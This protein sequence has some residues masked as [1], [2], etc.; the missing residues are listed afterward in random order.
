MEVGKKSK[1][2]VFMFAIFNYSKMPKTGISDDSEDE[3]EKASLLGDKQGVVQKGKGV[4]AAFLR[5][6]ALVVSSASVQLLE[7]RIPDFELNTVRCAVPFL[8]SAIGMVT[9][10]QLPVI[11]REEIGSTTLYSL[12]S[13]TTSITMY[14]AVTLLPVSTMQ[15][16]RETCNIISGII[17]FYIFLNE[18]PTCS[19][20]ISA[21][22]CICGVILVI[23]PSFIFFNKDLRMMNETLILFDDTNNNGNGTMVSFVSSSGIMVNDSMMTKRSTLKDDSS[24]ILEILKYSLPLLSGLA[25]C[26]DVVLVKKRPYLTE[27][28]TEVLF[29]C[30]M[31]NTIIS[32]VTMFIWE[33][34]VLPSSWFDTLLVTL[35]C[36]AY[37]FI[38]PLY[39]YSLRHIA[40]NTFVMICCTNVALFLLAQY[41]VLSSI[42]PGNRNWIEVI[43]V[44]FVLGGS[45]WVSVVEMF[46]QNK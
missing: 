11:S 12:L 15:S 36:L 38:W 8:L 40:G 5:L 20:F 14:V 23:Q 34:P 44:F 29:W 46:K 1:I 2:L 35:H 7:R 45:M 32:L 27:N 33:T 10:R 28:M 6:V 19:V 4:L 3:R 26:S 37:V 43:G 42:L 30:F 13:S 39:F 21:S 17:L 31:S 25:L 16:L 18:K 41:T 22:M 24:M 9:R